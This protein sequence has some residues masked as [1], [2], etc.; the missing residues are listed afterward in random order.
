MSKPAARGT[1]LITG[2][3]GGIGVVFADRFAKRG[4]GIIAGAVCMLIGVSILLWLLLMLVGSAN[5]RDLGQW[6]DHD[7]AVRAWFQ[8]LM[9]PDDPGHHEGDAYWADEVHYAN[10]QMIAVITD[11]RDDG[12]LRR[13]HGHPGAEYVVLPSKIT[14]RDG[15]PIGS[16]PRAQM[17][18]TPPMHRTPHGQL[19]GPRHTLPEVVVKPPVLMS[20]ESISMLRRR[21]ACARLSHPYYDVINTTPFSHDVNHRGFDRSSSWW[22]EASSYKAAPKG[23]PSSLIQH[24][25]LTPS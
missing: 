6:E 2:A 3:S 9:Q 19:V 22:F 5:A 11:T 4:Y 1:A 25:A 12:P 18:V 13:M 15:N 20:S 17:R 21:F 8:K 7:A 16:V 14:C 10:G 24:G 23:L